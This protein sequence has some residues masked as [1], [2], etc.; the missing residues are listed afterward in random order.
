MSNLVQAA[1]SAM[2]MQERV[3]ITYSLNISSE[4]A[5]VNICWEKAV[6]IHEKIDMARH[7]FH[8]VFLWRSS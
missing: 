4:K 2:T 8:H 7:A 3:E 5:L 6:D 1:P